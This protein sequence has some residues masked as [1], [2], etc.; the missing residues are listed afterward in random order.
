MEYKA[1]APTEIENTEITV[2]INLPNNIPEIINSGAPNPSSITQITA[3]IKKYI[4]L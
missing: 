2:P 4:R 1:K 3:K